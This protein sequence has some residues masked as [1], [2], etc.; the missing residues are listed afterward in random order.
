MASRVDLSLVAD[1]D[2]EPAAM[3][4]GLKIQDAEYLH[5]VCRD[6]ILVPQHADVPKAHRLDERLGNLGVWHRPMATVPA[7]DAK[8]TEVA[9]IGI[10]PRN[11]GVQR[12]SAPCHNEKG[13]KSGPNR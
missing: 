9:E 2:R 3:H 8:A 13:R 1:A 7:D 11:I 6:G 5:A 4:A 12:T 10:G